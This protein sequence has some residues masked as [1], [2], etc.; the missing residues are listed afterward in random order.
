MLP[1]AEKIRQY[2]LKQL[3]QHPE[4][5]VAVAAQHFSVT[6]T[7]IHRHL[8]H[9]LKHEQIFK[10]GITRNIRY[11]L[12]SAIDRQMQYKISDSISEFAIFQRDFEDLLQPFSEN[13]YDICSYGFTEILN[14]ALSH[15]HGSNILVS[16]TYPHEDLCITISDDGDGVFKIIADYFGFSDLRESALQLSKGK[17]TTNPEKH[18][19]EGIFFC[20]RAFDRFEIYA[21]NLHYI[22]D[23]QTQDWGLET[24]N[25]KMEG[26]S[27]HMRINRDTPTS[28]IGVLKQY[29]HLDDASFSRTEVLVKLSLWGNEPLISREQA[30]RVT[31]GLEKFHHIILDFSDVRLIGQG[32]VDELFRVFK[33]GHPSISIDYIHANPD[34]TFMIKPGLS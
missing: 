21:N 3:P 17:F 28:L 29:Q 10:S 20:S 6:R 23:N 31:L 33:Q 22:R 9:L 2:I 34:V 32:W 19:G 14:N 30:K 7:T 11:R 8:N 18:N 5:I 27:I 24:I 4:D 25:S 13:L 15:S 16:T 26:S 12:K 1:Q